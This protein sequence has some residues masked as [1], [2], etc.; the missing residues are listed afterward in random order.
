MQSVAK[1]TVTDGEAVFGGAGDIELAW[2]D[3]AGS[4]TYIK[5]YVRNLCKACKP[6]T[7]SAAGRTHNAF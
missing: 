2:Q 4:G 3:E 7:S 6:F 5:R 1:C